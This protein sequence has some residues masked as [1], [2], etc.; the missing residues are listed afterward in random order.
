M[1][2]RLEIN[3][4]PAE[5]AKLERAVKTHPKP[6]LRERA[7]AMVKISEGLSGREVALHRLNRPHAPDTIYDWVKLYRQQGLEGLVIKEGRGRKP[8][9]SP[10]HPD[11]ASAREALL[12]MLRRDP[13]E[14]GQE[15]SRWRAE[16]IRA[17]CSWLR[18]ASAGGLSR[19][20]SRLGISYKRGRQHVHSP[21]PDYLAKLG[22]VLA[23]QQEAL[24]RPEAVVLLFQDE[25]SY[26]RQPTLA[27]DDAPRGAAQPL[28]ELGY[29]C[30]QR[31]RI[32]AVLHALTGATYAEQHRCTGVQQIVAFYQRVCQLYPQAEVIYMRL[33]HK[34]SGGL[35]ERFEADVQ[36]Q[37]VLK[38]IQQ[39]ELVYPDRS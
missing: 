24:Q 2:K 9:F 12:H 16:D 10:Q 29:R 3:L 21:D 14:L 36:V 5:R 37:A 13:R 30:N 15:G 18:L 20:L 25:F 39:G 26:Y 8:A 1:P 27:Q 7:A 28:A 22:A 17:V 33:G 19:L 35:Q 32:I 11:A 31:Q 34:S 4:E 38:A 6:Y 23:Y